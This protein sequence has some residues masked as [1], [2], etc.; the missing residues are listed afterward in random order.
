M[1][2]TSPSKLT[3]FP[4]N[5][6]VS[7]KGL[8]KVA[9]QNAVKDVTEIHDHIKL[10]LTTTSDKSSLT[11]LK[12]C[13]HFYKSAMNDIKDSMAALGTKGDKDANEYIAAAANIA[14]KC[15]IE[16]RK[17]SRT[18]PLTNLKTKFKNL[19]TIGLALTFQMGYLHGHVP[20]Y[21]VLI[22][23][24]S[25]N[26]ILANAHKGPISESKPATVNVFEAI[27][28]VLE[29]NPLTNT[30]F[31][32]LAKLE[33]KNAIANG[34]SI[35]DRISLELSKTS[36]PY[37]KRCLTGCSANYKDAIDLIK[38]S[39]AALDAKGY[40]DAKKWILGAT[41][42]SSACEDRFQELVHK[43]SPIADMKTKFDWRC[44][45]SKRLINSLAKKERLIST[46]VCIEPSGKDMCI[47]TVEFILENKGLGLPG[48]TKLAVEKALED[49]NKIY[50]HI[51]VLL[52]TTSDKYV[53][54][55][56]KSC[57]EFYQ[58]AI[59]K[60]KDSLPALDSKR[61][62]DAN[63]W[64]GAATD[65]ANTCEDMF[66]E[67]ATVASPLTAMKPEFE[68]LVG[69]ALALIN[70]IAGN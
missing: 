22:L 14:E 16:F 1:E 18:S 20:F 5:E 42:L 12:H 67:K 34:T 64:V 51:N 36:N 52:R 48:M 23:L 70:S 58:T 45:R 44:L 49:G 27:A 6:V 37:T 47:S 32:V 33:L 43:N 9:V 50:N 30:D 24:L 40:S 26:H 3:V 68:K 56:L 55:N 13:S 35:Y 31:K 57:S 25:S 11:N 8:T 53:Q 17:S 62:A 28:K 21:F 41:A 4:G 38:K 61:Y 59:E 54:E 10:L 65:W 60:M 7:L 29:T 19:C 46:A 63:I 66:T 39:L 2:V 15:E 69:I